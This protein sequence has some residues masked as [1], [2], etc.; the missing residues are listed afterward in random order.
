MPKLIGPTRRLRVTQFISDQPCRFHTAS[1]DPSRKA[2]GSSRPVP[3]IDRSHKRTF[4]SLADQLNY[5]S[6]GSGLGAFPVFGVP[7]G[8]M[9]RRTCAS[10]SATGQC[11]TPRRT[12]NSWPGYS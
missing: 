5:P 1:A 7:V 3:D 10:S 6:Q 2:D 11:S 8:S 12:T 4:G 9:S